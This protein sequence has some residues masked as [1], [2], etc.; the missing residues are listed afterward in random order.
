MKNKFRILT[1]LIILAGGAAAVYLVAEPT[2]SRWK[3][4]KQ[5]REE[6]SRNN[7]YQA[8]IQ[9]LSAKNIAVDSA[10]DRLLLM[11]IARLEQRESIDAKLQH[12]A[13]LGGLRLDGKGEYLQQGRGDLR[14]LRW[15]LESQHDGVRASLLLCMNDGVM[16]IDRT[17]ATG[18]HIQQIDLWELRRMQKRQ[19]LETPSLGANSIPLSSQLVGNVGGLPMLLESLRANFEFTKPGVFRAPPQLGLGDQPVIGL[20]GRW[21]HSALPSVLTDL[22]DVPDEE[23][24]ASLITERLQKRLEQS[25]LPEWMPLNVMVLLGQ[26]DLFPYLIEYRSPDDQ[27]ANEE[28]AASA[29]FQLSREPLARLTMREVEFNRPISTVEFIYQPP[30][31]P[32]WDDGTNGYVKKLEHS[33]AI[34]VA[35]RESGKMANLPDDQPR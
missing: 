9:R 17:N 7:Q 6:E 19:A 11:A 24:S 12:E 13:H 16:W 30:S 22:S 23:L 29:L 31:E 5:T 20:I 33:Q 26:E 32:L 21:R 3:A 2:I 1:T 8:N 10:G 27:L 25:P 28:L 14:K 18:R 35:Q 4:D 34:Q 15:L